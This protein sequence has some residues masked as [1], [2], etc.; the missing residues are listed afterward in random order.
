MTTYAI[1]LTGDESTWESASEEDRSAM[2]AK[3]GEFARLLE[4][5]QHVLPLVV[6][7]RLQE[8]AQPV[9]S[10]NRHSLQQL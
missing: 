7:R 8:L 2:Y 10:V 9:A 5:R 1:L 4:E 6:V 3:H